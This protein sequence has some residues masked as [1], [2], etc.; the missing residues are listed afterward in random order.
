MNP[1]R[2]LD[3]AELR[4]ALDAL[5]DTLAAQGVPASI[6]V[7][8]GAAIAARHDQR[9]LTVDVDAAMALRPTLGTVPMSCRV[10]APRLGP[11]PN[12]S[13]RLAT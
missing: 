8:G 7:V 12:F 10:R 9:R 5:S 2:Q 3:A 6:L 13:L 11:H 1:R 4:A